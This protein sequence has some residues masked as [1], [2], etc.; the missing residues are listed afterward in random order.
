[1]ELNISRD[2]R[3]ERSIRGSIYSSI[4]I[5]VVDDEG[6]CLSRL[7][8]FNMA[9]HIKRLVRYLIQVCVTP[10]IQFI[11]KLMTLTLL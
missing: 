10:Y 3:I 8:C 5:I 4:K 1:V 7:R 2:M 9:A 6:G 11:Q